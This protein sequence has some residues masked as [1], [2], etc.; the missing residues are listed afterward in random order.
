MNMNSILE[1]TLA[2]IVAENHQTAA[3]FE[4]YSLDFCCKGKRILKEACMEK[5]IDAISLAEELEALSAK[6]LSHTP[7]ADMTADELIGYILIHHHF[8]V[9]QSMPTIMLHLEK[10]AMKHGPNFPYM[11]EVYQLFAEIEK[12]MSSHM[13]KEE[14][15]LFPRIKQVVAASSDNQALPDVNF[16]KD[17]ISVME[18]EH[19]SAGDIMSEIRVLTNNYT[20]PED[21]C[22]TF[23]V[24]IAELQAFE[25]DLHKHVHLENHI[26]FPKAENIFLN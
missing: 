23:R 11:I 21:A 18:H 10:V 6:P 16:I 4:K 17:P 19:D 7:F 8:Y 5:N 14:N 1:K 22:T 13:Q 26:L 3:I 25:E 12:D 20:T 15:I 2:T 9:K 24:V